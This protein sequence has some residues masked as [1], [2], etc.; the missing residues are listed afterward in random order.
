VDS[1]ATENFI[2]PEATA[3]A[4]LQTLKKQV[5]YRLHLA[6]RQL[7]KGNRVIQYETQ[8]FKIQLEQHSERIKIDLVPLGGYQMILGIL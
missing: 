2:A 1:E 5:L 8:E 7:A 3:S 6:N 4:N